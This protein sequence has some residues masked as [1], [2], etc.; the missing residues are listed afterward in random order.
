MRMLLAQDS[1]GGRR[2]ASSKPAWPH[3]KGRYRALQK[4]TSGC[5]HLFEGIMETLPR[6]D[7]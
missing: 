5:S 1:G 2:L 6:S 3:E 7:I 4:H